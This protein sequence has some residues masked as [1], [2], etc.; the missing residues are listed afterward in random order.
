MTGAPLTVLV[1]DDHAVVRNGCRRLLEPPLGRFR[2]LEAGDG[3]AALA[4]LA[5][6]PEV[7]AVVCDLNMPGDPAGIG[8]VE[9]LA[10]AGPAVV[11]LS[12]HE[13][14]EVAARCVAAGA[15]GYLSKSD[16]PGDLAQAVEAALAGRAWI[17]RDAARA[18]AAG[19]APPDRDLSPREREAM[20]L[21]G[22]TTDLQ[23]IA[24]GLGVSRKTTA[25]LLVR[26]R[27]RHGVRR[28]ADLVR[29][30]VEGRDG[31]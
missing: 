30:A 2:V 10:S 14:P 16:D 19:A 3:A 21:L 4:L 15:A 7:A 31:P 20:R 24:A 1:V 27:A 25:N 11:V 5:E 23:A 12:M 6:R 17:S 13:A 26:L 29:I 28:T 22:R 9:R 8:L 18:I